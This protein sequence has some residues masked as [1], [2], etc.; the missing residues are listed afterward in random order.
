M[1]SNRVG[2][3]GNMLSYSIWLGDSMGHEWATFASRTFV[4]R[5]LEALVSEIIRE[6]S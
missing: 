6:Y 3:V 1:T 4:P 5:G 2:F